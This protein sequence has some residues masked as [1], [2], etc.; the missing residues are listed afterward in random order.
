[1]IVWLPEHSPSGLAQAVRTALGDSSE[2]TWHRIEAPP[3]SHSPVE[4]LFSTFVT[5]AEPHNL[6]SANT[7]VQQAAFSEKIIWLENLTDNNW[8]NWK[9]FL[10]SYQHVCHA[11]SIL[12]RTLF[13]IP[14]VGDVGTDLP[15]DDV[16][17]SK[18]IWK[19]CIDQFD[20]LLFLSRIFRDQNMPRI[21]KR[22]A[23]SIAVELAQWD[24]SLGEVLSNESLESILTPE[25]VLHDFA[26]SRGWT[27]DF[28]QKASFSN[29]MLNR[30]DGEQRLHSA[31]VVVRGDQAEI[32]RRIWSGQVG[33]VF[34]FVE[35]KRR[36][37]IQTLQGVLKV[38]YTTR[39]GERIVDVRELE[40]GHIE[41]QLS[42]NAPMR[43][44]LLFRQVQKL[45]EARNSLSH[46][47]TLSV[48]FLL[49]DAFVSLD[50]NERDR[51]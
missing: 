46:L 17:L 5:C 41:S 39:F 31:A 50:E 45:R 9:A 40:I 38:P 26:A 25:P 33:I 11:R 12:E 19:D 27:E 10:E 2:A 51:I 49:S 35:E 7:L 18:H 30:C 20:M 48:E 21:R 36:Q 24:P 8:P 28:C 22:I 44:S 4:F 1:M 29:G 43:G 47:E 14:L 13:C 16:C 3:A 34:P 6:R 15:K 42:C 37:I 32:E 23:I